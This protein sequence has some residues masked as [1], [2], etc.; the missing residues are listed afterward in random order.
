MKK[1]LAIL[2]MLLISFNLVACTGDNKKTITVYTAIEEEY[3]GA[4]LDDFH[5]KHP[6]IKVNL[7]RDSSGV[8]A[9]KLLIEKD[10]PRADVVWGLAASNMVFL[11]KYGVFEPYKVPNLN[12]L[13]EI[14]YDTANEVPHWVANGGWMNIFAVNEK[15]LED[16]GIKV[17]TNYEDLLS[18]DFRGSLAMPNPASSGTGYLIVSGLIQ[19]MGEEK[20][21]EYMDEL[22]KNMKEYSH[23]GTAPVKQA[24]QGELLI[25]VGADYTAIQME[26]KGEHIKTIFPEGGS[27]WELEVSAL[28][29]NDKITEE[30]KIFYE[31][32][33][34]EVMLKNYADNRTL[35]PLKGYTTK[36]G[37]AYDGDITKQMIPYNLES[38]SKERNRI[39]KE[40]EKRY[41]V[42]E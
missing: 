9:S 21:W 11:D 14:F 16:K 6:D 3:I 30:A 13:N 7:V 37:M 18:E 40:W 26:E 29:S 36:L 34:S 8:V 19:K 4:Y 15:E 12:E 5:A 33:V 28:I 17:P 20:A 39:L 22:N 35:T 41:G 24:A 42:G 23:S 10:N 1:I 2:L 25:G 38:V 27:G 31:W 32:C